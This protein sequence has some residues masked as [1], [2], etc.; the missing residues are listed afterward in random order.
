MSLWARVFPRFFV[1]SVPT[2][3]E[4]F[5]DTPR[6]NTMVFGLTALAVVAYSGLSLLFKALA[7][8]T[9]PAQMVYA[10]SVI[11]TIC[12]LIYFIAS[13]E[14]WSWPAAILAFLAGVT[15]YFATIA[16]AKAL[17]HS[18]A[19][20]VFAI[21]N[22][23][24]VVAGVIILLLPAAWNMLQVGS[25]TINLPSQAGNPT[26]GNLLAC[27]LTAVAVL[28]GAQVKGSEKLSNATYV[29]LGLLVVS[30]F[31]AVTYARNFG[32]Q[33]GLLMFVDFAAGVIPGLHLTPQV[34]R[35]EWGW[36]AVV[37]LI[38]FGGFVAMMHA[39]AMSDAATLP[40]VLLA[41]N[42]KTPITAIIAV[43]LFRE[44]LTARKI[45]AVSLA[46]LALFIWQI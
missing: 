25:V 37:G 36:G 42:L 3:I 40:F 31:A 6:W 16:R 44:Q 9:R 43:P 35:H 18:P 46:T 39:Q 17:E 38:T 32:A 5:I 30:S 24:L 34:R 15:F 12:G 20:L 8:R 13:G 26:L 11:A 23:D 28:I 45:I 41:I 29:C 7:S 21:S 22:L 33:I 1:V 14:S 4:L 19:S 2:S 10:S 27:V